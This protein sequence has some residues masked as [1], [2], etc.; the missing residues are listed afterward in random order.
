MISGHWSWEA[1]MAHGAVSVVDKPYACH[2]GAHAFDFIVGR[3]KE[4]EAIS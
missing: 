4:A 2:A 3:L 1:Q